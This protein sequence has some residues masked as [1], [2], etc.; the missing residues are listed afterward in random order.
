LIVEST[1]D[2]IYL[3]GDLTQDHWNAIRTAVSL[4]LKRHPAGVIVDISQ[5]E[6]CTPEGAETFLHALRYIE[7]GTARF[8]LANAPD[9]VRQ[10][11]SKVPGVRSQLPIAESID[12]ARQS[13]NLLP[14]EAVSAPVDP[15]LVS[16]SGESVDEDAIEM[17]AGIAK[18]RGSTLCLVYLIKVPRSLALTAP[19]PEREAE[20]KRVL[21]AAEAVSKRIGAK[22]IYRA[23][24][25][26]GPHLGLAE[27]ATQLD[28]QLIVYVLPREV[29][30]TIASAESL[31]ELLEHA[32]C[33]VV[34][35][36]GPTHL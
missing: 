7:K 19:L 26:R 36:R 30:V 11:L 31:G 9:H 16:L 27:L 25:V 23:Q 35:Y 20:A 3:S 17:A 28:A 6:R 5:I 18:H 21:S 29:T 15:V 10:A 13:L 12:E 14:S 4:L 32:S 2:V 34:L 33:E 8:I 24:R 1:D 22:P